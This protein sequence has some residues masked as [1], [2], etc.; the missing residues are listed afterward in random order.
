[1][2]SQDSPGAN[3][4]ARHDGDAT[5][6]AAAGTARDA[7]GVGARLLRIL[8]GVLAIE[9]LAMAAVVVF[10]TVEQFVDA[11]A[12]RVSSIA[13]LA[14]TVVA[15]AFLVAILVGAIRRAPWV[16]AAAITWQVLQLAAAWTVVQGDLAPLIGWVMT[17]LSVVGFVVAL[18]PAT[19]AQ[20]RARARD[21]ALD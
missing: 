12:S 14:T 19:Q 1:M 3:S 16:R 18:L 17:A 5:T 13:L 21:A 20:L 4:A 10:L 7:T 2:P 8:I 15:L 9:T 6:D 11:P